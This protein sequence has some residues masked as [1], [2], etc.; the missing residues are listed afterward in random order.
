MSAKERLLYDLRKGRLASDQFWYL[1]SFLV[2]LPS[3]KPAS[4]K[5]WVDGYLSTQHSLPFLLIG[6]SRRWTSALSYF[7]CAHVCAHTEVEN[8][9]WRSILSFC[10]MGPG[11][12]LGPGPQS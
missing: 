8:N 11:D 3:G 1:L 6:P 7:I 2:C 5:L 12:L 4:C 10:H 9:L